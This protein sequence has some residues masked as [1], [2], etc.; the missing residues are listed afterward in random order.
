MT[1]RCFQD[2]PLALTPVSY[3]RYKSTM[4]QNPIASQ[5]GVGAN[6][7]VPSRSGIPTGMRAVVW[8]ILIGAVEGIVIGAVEEYVT[9]AHILPAES[10]WSAV[11]SAMALVLAAGWTM[12]A[13]WHLGDPRWLAR[14]TMAGGL[15]LLCALVG[16]LATALGIEVKYSFLV[17]AAIPALVAGV[18]IAVVFAKVV[19]RE[20]PVYVAAGIGW[21]IIGW[22]VA[23]GLQ[24]TPAPNTVPLPDNI[25]LW[26][27]E[28]IWF[29]NVPLVLTAPLLATALIRL[30]RAPSARSALLWLVAGAILLPLAV[31]GF[32]GLTVHLIPD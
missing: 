24:A 25:P 31:A 17:V 27:G 28:I 9:A 23:T 21:L 22:I 13:L 11:L 29:L 10:Y 6:S 20:L 19:P 5:T 1:G 15:G 7:V 14:S 4:A 26:V 18:A 30:D 8:I 16:A 12:L 32:F 2:D 3:E